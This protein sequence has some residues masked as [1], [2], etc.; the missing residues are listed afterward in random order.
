MNLIDFQYYGTKFVK[1]AY[2]PSSQISNLVKEDIFIAVNL[3]ING[4]YNFKI[5]QIYSL[6]NIP[7]TI[8]P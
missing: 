4:K 8:M 1:N 7:L 2:I 5:L 3:V 6:E